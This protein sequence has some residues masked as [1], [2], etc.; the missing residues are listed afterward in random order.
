[1]NDILQALLTDA[2]SD[3]LSH[4]PR[5]LAYVLAALTCFLLGTSPGMA[6]RT[7]ARLRQRW[8]VLCTLYLLVAANCL[9]QGDVLWV[10]WAR[11]FFRRQHLYEE[12][13][14]F[15]LVALLVLF[16]LASKVWQHGQSVQRLRVART[17]VLYRLLLMG[18]AGTLAM[19]LLRDV[20]FHYIDLV[21]NTFWLHHSVASWVEGAS[22]GLAGLATGLEV[23]RS[24]GHV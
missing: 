10:H 15:Q 3:D 9:V 16:L 13:R 17:S 19:L 22:L 4:W 7:S 8:L 18:A 6:E 23:L 20:S 24:Y 21:L 11:T 14:F 5:S 12:R 2:G 1:M